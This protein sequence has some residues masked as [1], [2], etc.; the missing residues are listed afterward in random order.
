MDGFFQGRK[1]VEF[2]WMLSIRLVYGLK[3][4]NQLNSEKV[5]K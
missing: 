4:S 5:W 2:T 3:L 1:Y